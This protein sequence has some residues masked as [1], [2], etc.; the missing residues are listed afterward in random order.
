MDFTKEKQMIFEHIQKG[1]FPKN[2]EEWGGANLIITKDSNV[3][4]HTGDLVVYTE[5]ASPYSWLLEEL[6][7]VY[8]EKINFINK[9]V[10]I[11]EYGEIIQNEIEKNTDLFTSLEEVFHYTVSKWD[12]I[13]VESKL[14][15]HDDDDNDEN[16]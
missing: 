10:F 1:T 5:H 7:R 11:G 2:H 12:A 14:K 13:S 15:N 4:G 6:F 8:S 16:I 9:Y 3:K